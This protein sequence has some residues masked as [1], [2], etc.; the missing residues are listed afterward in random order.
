MTE[1]CD[2]RHEWQRVLSVYLT[3]VVTAGNNPTLK[4]PGEPKAVVP[5]GHFAHVHL[6][7]GTV[8]GMRSMPCS[9][10]DQHH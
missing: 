4:L 2:E 5:L 1:V 3:F 7:V 10:T 9:W 8:A 6:P